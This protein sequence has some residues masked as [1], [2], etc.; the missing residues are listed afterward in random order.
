MPN[1]IETKLSLSEDLDD[2]VSD[3][4]R[5]IMEE[6]ISELNAIKEN[7][8]NISTVYVFD[9]GEQIEVKVYFRNGF[10]RKINF[11]HIQLAMV[12]SKNEVLG[13]KVFVLSE[14]GD[15]PP[16]TARPWKLLFNKS[17]IDMSKFSKEGCKIV[18]GEK[19][20]AVNYAHITL[21]DSSVEEEKYNQMFKD[22]IKTL[23]KM[24]KGKVSLSRFKITLQKEGKII[25][26]LIIRNS[27]EKSVTIEKLPITIKDKNGDLIASG[28]FNTKDLKVESMKARV[29]NFMFESKLI[30]IEQSYAM[31]NWE[32]FF[33]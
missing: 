27:C 12:N 17:E 15:L 29:C 33:E 2:I 20:R 6:E 4:Q 5:E 32:V 16:G 28:I 14:M 21:D 19:V 30:H 18:F 24:E 1:N 22:F 7:D 13:K 25:V 31:N 10:S 3:V 23:P 9:D 26:T 11:D 8:V